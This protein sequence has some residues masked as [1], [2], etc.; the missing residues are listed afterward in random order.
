[1]SDARVKLGGMG[2]HVFGFDLK[3]DR[4]S[5]SEELRSHGIHL[6]TT[7]TPSH[8]A[9][10]VRKQLPVDSATIAIASCRTRSSAWPQLQRQREADVFFNSARN[11]DGCRSRR[12]GCSGSW[13]R[14]VDRPA[15]GTFSDFGGDL[16][17]VDGSEADIGCRLRQ[18]ISHR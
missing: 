4:A 14:D 5:S 13:G 9:R 8:P 15:G 10:D 6:W 7:S 11:A 16:Q 17:H 12:E 2:M 18:L 1:M 3:L